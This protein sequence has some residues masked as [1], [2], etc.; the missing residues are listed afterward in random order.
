VLHHQQA[1]IRVVAGGIKDIGQEEAE[2][3]IVQ[4]LAF[5]GIVRQRYKGHVP[6]IKP[7]AGR[8][9]MDAE[10]QHAHRLSGKGDVMVMPYVVEHVLTTHGQPHAGSAHVRQHGSG[11]AR[12]PFALLFFGFGAGQHFAEIGRRA[13]GR[14]CGSGPVLEPR[15]LFPA[16][17]DAVLDFQNALLLRSLVLV[18]YGLA[19]GNETRG[20]HSRVGGAGFK[21]VAVHQGAP[22][23]GVFPPGII[24]FFGKP[25]AAPHGLGQ[26][27]DDA[28]RTAYRQAGRQIGKG[29][30]PAID[31]VAGR[32]IKCQPVWIMGRYGYFFHSGLNRGERD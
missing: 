25:L 26:P 18:Q 16:G 28:A 31:P 27:V 23:A 12:S 1:A 20:M 30:Q 2:H 29:R 15:H 17:N 3:F 11:G 5:P 10:F 21:R 14:Q 7:A 24:S 22:V 6:P 19:P 4:S 13:S 32:H 8:N 9:V